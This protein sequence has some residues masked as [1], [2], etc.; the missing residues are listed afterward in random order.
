VNRAILQHGFFS[1]FGNTGA[2]AAIANLLPTL[3]HFSC[4]GAVDWSTMRFC[5]ESVLQKRWQF[6]DRPTWISKTV[7]NSSHLST[8]FYR[9]PFYTA[10][11]PT[12]FCFRLTA[13]DMSKLAVTLHSWLSSA[14]VSQRHSTL[15]CVPL[16]FQQSRFTFHNLIQLLQPP[17]PIFHCWP[18]TTN[19]NTHK[20]IK[21][22]YIKIRMEHEVAQWLRYCATN[23]KVAG[24]IPDGVIGIFHWHNSSGRTMTLRST[25]PLTEVSTRNISW[26]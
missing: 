10:M 21:F 26:G 6:G 2:E 23:R 15:Y 19:S 24:S 20:H 1:W 18:Q 4:N 12:M 16:A 13:A 17:G 7:R 14:C 22:V 9:W 8:T 25:Q 11:L 5:C 3:K